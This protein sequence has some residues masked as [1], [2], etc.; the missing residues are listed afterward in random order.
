MIREGH[1]SVYDLTLTVRAPLFIGNGQKLGKIDYLYDGR[2]ER[3]TVLDVGKLLQFLLEKNLADSYEQFI[4]SGQTNMY[5]FLKN[6]CALSYGEIQKL[7][8][9]Q[10]RTS[11]A[12]SEVRSLKEIKQFIRTRDNQV[13]VPGSSVKGALRTALL[14]NPVLQTEP[15]PEE[16]LQFKFKLD[17]KRYVNTLNYLHSTKNMTGDMTSSVLQGIRISDSSPVSNNCIV[18]ASKADAS[19]DGVVKSLNVLWECIAPGTKLHFKMTLDHSVLD[20]APFDG[21]VGLDAGTILRAVNGF[22]EYYQN[23][24]LS[25]FHEPAGSADISWENGLLLGGNAG[26]FS[27]SLAYPYFKERALDEVSDYMQTGFPIHKHQQ[28]S[29]LGISPHVMNYARYSGKYYPMGL[30]GVEIT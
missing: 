3:L 25:V 18:L 22:S 23:H 5:T 26:F 8:L 10:V 11:G 30:C 21:A 4:L 20:H 16:H 1:L 6:I 17:E 28:D 15:G 27:K 9:Y 14:L 2:N 29:Q 19:I 12:L 13:Y 24:Y 7:G